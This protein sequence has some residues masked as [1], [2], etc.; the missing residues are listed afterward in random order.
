MPSS[1]TTVRPSPWYALPDHLCRFRV[2][3]ARNIARGFSRQPRITDF[4]CY[5]SASRLGLGWWADLP[6]HRPTRLP[7]LDHRPGSATFL[8]HPIAQLLPAGV[9]AARGAVP[10]GAARVRV[11]SACGSRRGRSVAGTGISTRCPS[12]TPLG[13]ALGPDSPRADWPGPGTLG[14]SAEG[15]L[16]LLALLMPAFSLAPPPRLDHSGASPVARRSPTHPHAW[17][18]ARCAR[19]GFWCECHSFGGVLEPR[20][21]VGAEPLDQ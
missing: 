21:I 5:G 2:R 14:H 10:E 17:T 7:R 15:V 19:A 18:H 12:T 1:L 9:P 20:Y 4:A 13:L 3:A 11:V 8:R 6:T 16:T